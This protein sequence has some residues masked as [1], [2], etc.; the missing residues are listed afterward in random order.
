MKQRREGKS[1]GI[2]NEGEH[3]LEMLRKASNTLEAVINFFKENCL[4]GSKDIAHDTNCPS[5]SVGWATS[6]IQIKGKQPKLINKL[7]I[8]VMSE[9]RYYKCGTW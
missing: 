1:K 7:T 2:M 8:D 6:R 5:I 3:L 4:G 9:E